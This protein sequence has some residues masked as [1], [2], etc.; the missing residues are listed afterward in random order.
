VKSLDSDK[1]KIQQLYQLAFQ[2]SAEEE[3]IKLAT[4]FLQSQAATFLPPDT[5]AW[6]YGYGHFDE[7]TRRVENFTPLPHWTGYAW[8]GGTNLPDPKLGWVIL[9]ADGGHVGNDLNHAAIRRWC[10]PRDGVVSIQGEFH[11][12]SDKG[13]GVRARIVSARQGELGQWTAQHNQ[14]ATKLERIEVKQGDFID[15]VTDCRSSVE[16]DSFYWA[17]VIK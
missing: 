16:F 11:H 2:R 10:A 14:T 1:A 15:F 9:N 17:P 7:A 4:R 8:Q 13:D 6:S 5:P 12:P 3:E